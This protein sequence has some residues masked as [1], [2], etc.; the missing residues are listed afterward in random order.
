MKFGFSTLGCP[1]WS[2]SDILVAASDLG[3][4]GVE[5]RGIGRDVYL[6]NTPLF[7][8]TEKIKKSLKELGHS[9]PCLASG[10]LLHDPSR[11][12]AARSEAIAYI[13]LAAALGVPYVRVLGDRGPAPGIV[14]DSCVIDNLNYLLIIAKDAG[15]KLLIETNGV[16]G[17]SAKLRSLLEKIGSESLG[18]LW[19]VHHPY[20][21]FGESVQTTYG[22]LK[23][24]IRH[25]HVKD[26]VREKGIVRYRMTGQGDV[27][28]FDAVTTLKNGGYDGF[29]MLEWVRRWDA[30]L[31]EPGIVLP[32]FINEMKR[33][34]MGL[35]N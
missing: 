2:F 14:N 16:F 19:D 6:P 13:E 35:S 17:D 33:H 22:N 31:E 24:F 32:H 18:V 20:R 10:A 28:V 26:S 11:A 25:I 5:L 4:D 34:M 12:F 9:V 21:F 3:F 29:V 7:N 30:G 8:Y 23:P 1:E 27:P 15:I